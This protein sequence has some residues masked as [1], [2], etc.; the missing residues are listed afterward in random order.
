MTREAEA[1]WAADLW[2]PLPAASFQAY[3][4]RR[5]RGRPPVPSPALT[6]A[7]VGS[8]KP[9][10]NGGTDMT[11]PIT[12]LL[13]YIGVG[14]SIAVTLGVTVDLIVKLLTSW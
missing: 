12:E 11:I 8:L 10:G 2:S 14:F 5:T 1:D 6:L 13:A 9:R 3:G 7:A 4:V